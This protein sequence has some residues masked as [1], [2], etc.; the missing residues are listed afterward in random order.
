M[1]CRSLLSQPVS[2]LGSK[3]YDHY[4]FANRKPNTSHNSADFG[5]KRLISFSKLL[6][7]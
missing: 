3:D 7:T 2:D 1:F 6:F 5:F 4:A